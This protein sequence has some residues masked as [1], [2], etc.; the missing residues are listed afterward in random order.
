[1]MRKWVQ[2]SL[3]VLGWGAVVAAVIGIVLHVVDWSQKSMVLLASG[4]MWLMLGAVVGLVLMLLARGWRSS[5]A[6]ALVL[7]GAAWLVVPSYIPEARAAAGPEIVVLQS[8]ILFGLADPNAV[9]STVRDNNVD[10]LTVEELTHDS[11]VRLREA[12]L[13]ERLPYFYTEATESGGGGTGIYSRY[14]LRDTKKYDGFT[15][16][17]ISAIME[18][19]Q[20]GPMP[21]FAFHPIPPNLDFAAWSAEMRKIDEILAAT[22]APAIVGA[23][24]NATHDHSAYRALLDG[25]FASAAD[26]TGDGVLLT[27]PDDRRWGPVIGIDHILVAGGVAEQIRTLTIPGSDHRAVLATIRMDL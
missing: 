12:G 25:A 11:I 4:A 2:R 20:R 15:M 13:E 1:M 26:Q 9:V 5:G 21:V 17:N 23:D 27:W 6:A 3:L 7:A 16:S 14:P 24:F 22:S 8:N 18:H 10:V 19:P